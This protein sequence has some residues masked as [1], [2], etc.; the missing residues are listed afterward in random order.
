MFKL[1][2]Q[3]SVFF[4][5]VFISALNFGCDNKIKG[6]Y[7]SPACTDDTLNAAQCSTAANRYVTATAGANVNGAAGSLSASISDGYYSGGKTCTMSDADLVVGNIRSGVDIFGT[8]G[9]FTGSFSSSM[10]SSAGRDPGSVVNPYITVQGTSTQ[11]TLDAE[12]TTYA[13]NGGT[14]NLPTTGGYYYRDVPDQSV[15][16]EGYLGTNC[17]Y[18]P[19]S[20]VDCGTTEATIAGRIAACATANPATSTWDG[21]TQCN[22]GQ[23]V[24]KL[25]VRNGANKEVWQDQ[26]TGLLWSSVVS[27]SVNWCQASG[28]TQNAPVS[29]KA[30]YNNAAGTP[31]TGDGTIGSISGGS[32]S[33]DEDITIT[34][35]SATAFTVSGVCGGGA[36]TG[37]GLTTTAGSTVTWGRANNCSFTITQGAVNFAVNDK[38]VID[39]DA[40]AS[41]S[42]AAGAAAGLQPASPV[43]YCAEAA[44]LNAPAGEN[45]GTGTYMAAKGLLG[46]NSTPGVR[47]RLPHIEDYKLADVN[48]IR[49]VL[50]DMGIAGTSR[51][52][53]DGSTGSAS[54]EWS[55]SVDSN[56]RYYSWSFYG[57]SGDV[58][59]YTRISSNLARC[60]GR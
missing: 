5:M 58:N 55:A 32:S 54:Y 3:K 27:T 34:F 39:S 53:I 21:S 49:F 37:G 18:A 17:E 33:A 50:P 57:S 31:I 52:I 19:R 41:Y 35:T 59:N 24:W 38:F 42:C 29:F 40:A 46:K 23:G 36:V 51:P 10:A 8:V 44:G 2:K 47:W 22:R 6:S 48:G 56:V 15:D 1:F 11:L 26:R 25:V 13:G 20:S 7:G 14:P 45:W 43:S 12:T 16:D 30:A 28:N 60:V 4:V 9:T